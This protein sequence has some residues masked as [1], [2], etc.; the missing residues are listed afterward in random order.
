MRPKI[1]AADV[2]GWDYVAYID[3]VAA[4]QQR[5]GSRTSTRELERPDSVGALV[6]LILASLRKQDAASRDVHATRC[7]AEIRLVLHVSRRMNAANDIEIVSKQEAGK[8]TGTAGAKD[9]CANKR[10][11]F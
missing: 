1:T 9:F 8:G 5:F 3:L 7:G 4:A 10:A 11:M 2:E 6:S